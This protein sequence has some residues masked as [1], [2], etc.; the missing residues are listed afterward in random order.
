MTV[1]CSARVI[2]IGGLLLPL[3]AVLTTS[4][5]E[6]RARFNS[7]LTD[8]RALEATVYKRKERKVNPNPYIG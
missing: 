1:G 3:T 7:A 6:I 8:T 2:V 4:P 5:T